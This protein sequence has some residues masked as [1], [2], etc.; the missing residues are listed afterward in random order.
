MKNILIAI[1]AL[2]V[3]ACSS[4]Y[5][6]FYHP[7][8]GATPEAIAATRIGTPAATPLL[9]HA[10]STNL[11]SVLFGYKKRGYEMIGYSLY[12]S[13]GIAEDNSAIEQAKKVSADLVVILPASDYTNYK[14]NNNCCVKKITNYGALYF[15]KY[16]FPLGLIYR[17]LD[18]KEREKIQ[19]NHGVSVID[20]VND[21]PA[22]K[23]DILP[24]DIITAIN[25][26]PVYSVTDF[27]EYIKTHK[28]ISAKI[29]IT[30]NGNSVTKQVP[31]N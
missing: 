12:H 18:N 14:L 20:T 4:G 6:M 15:V 5:Q 31:T 24:G 29:T 21:S 27:N 1:M 10:Y 22:F 16:N 13:P 8:N 30:R 7:Q 9:E 3:T 23:A 17:N 25:D 26:N 11:N 19:S 2:G 28:N